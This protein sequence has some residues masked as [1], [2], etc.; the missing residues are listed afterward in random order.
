MDAEV[1]AIRS[2]LTALMGDV[3]AGRFRRGV[4]IGLGAAI[5]VVTGAVLVVQSG[6][7]AAGDPG[8]GAVL[9]PNPTVTIGEAVV[10]ERGGTQGPAAEQPRLRPRPRSARPPCSRETPTDLRARRRPVERRIPCGRVRNPRSVRSTPHSMSRERSSPM[11]SGCA[12]STEPGLGGPPSDR[13]DR[14]SGLRGDEPSGGQIPDRQP[15]L[16]VGIDP[17]RSD[18][19]QVERCRAHPPD[20]TDPG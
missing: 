12:T 15:H 9:P 17:A 3:G 8:T 6:A 20:I 2:D 16:E 19:A 18:G 10:L 7:T 5:A 14:G 11:R 4:L 1:G 13:F